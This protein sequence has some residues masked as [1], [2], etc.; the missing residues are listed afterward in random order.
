V[1][2]REGA[3]PLP[4]LLLEWGQLP[5]IFS[6]GDKHMQASSEPSRRK[7][8]PPHTPL[9]VRATEEGHC[10]V[11]CLACGLHGPER[12]NSSKA[13]LAFE[14]FSKWLE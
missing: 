10:V 5:S 2:S 3:G 12:E 9:L 8:C 7:P 13:R 6:K 14:Q 1:P 11:Q 4:A